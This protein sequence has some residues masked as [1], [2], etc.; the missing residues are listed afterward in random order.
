MS[1]RLTENRSQP[2]DHPGA[3]L[4]VRERVDILH[5]LLG[6]GH[7]RIYRGEETYFLSYQNG[8]GGEGDRFTVSRLTSS[9]SGISQLIYNLSGFGA[10]IGATEMKI[11]PDRK[12]VEKVSEYCSLESLDSTLRSL[13]A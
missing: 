4:S 3:S 7:Q 9:P 10:V 5:T 1:T 6:S 13:K 8:L 2:L 11:S 12:R